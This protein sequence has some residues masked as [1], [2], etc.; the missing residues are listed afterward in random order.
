MSKKIR[1]DMCGNDVDEA[2]VIGIE[3]RGTHLGFRFCSACVEKTMGEAH[4]KRAKYVVIDTD[5]NDSAV[6]NSE[7]EAARKVAEIIEEY[8]DDCF[9]VYRAYKLKVHAQ[10]TTTVHKVTIDD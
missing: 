1:C 10:Y 4:K 9:A 6:Y 3:I 2:D 7:E 8:G 5:S